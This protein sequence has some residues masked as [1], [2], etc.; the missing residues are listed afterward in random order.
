MRERLR[1]VEAAVS[2]MDTYTRELRSCMDNI[3]EQID[4]LEGKGKRRN[5]GPFRP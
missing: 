3:Q 1:S 4:R 5:D 2:C